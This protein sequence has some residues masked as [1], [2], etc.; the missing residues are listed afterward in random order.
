MAGELVSAQTMTAPFRGMSQLPF[1]RQI[2]LLLGLAASVAVGA[3]MILWMKDPDYQV[4]YSKLAARDQARI[5]EEL[6][7]VNIP[8]RI[9][10]GSGAVM[11]PAARL[12]DARMLVAGSGISNG[13]SA[14]YELM[15]NGSQFGTSEFMENARYQRALEGELAKSIQSIGVVQAARVHLALPK[16]SAFIRNQSPPTASV[17]VSLF[18]G[19]ALD[20]GK[21]AAIRN[22]VAAGVPNLDPARVSIV[23]QMGRLLAAGGAGETDSIGMSSSQ[24]D[25]TR[26]L[27]ESYRER[28]ESLMAPVIGIGGVRAQVAL[29]I[30][31]ST[32]EQTQESFQPDSR[33]VRSEQVQENAPAGQQNQGAAPAAEPASGVP[34]AAANQPE[35]AA[36][37]QTA[38][39]AEGAQPQ[40][41]GP[42][43]APETIKATRNYEVGKVISH[44]RAAPGRIK[45]L[46]AAVIID[47]R[48]APNAE[49]VM[50]K[51]PLT[52][53]EITRYTA[54]IK[55]AVGVDE[56]R[57]DSIQI[58]NTPFSALPEPQPLPEDPIYK[59]TWFLVVG[60]QLL[61][62]AVILLLL[63]GVLRPVLRSL[64]SRPV[65]APPIPQPQRGFSSAELRAMSQT[66]GMLPDSNLTAIRRGGDYERELLNARNMV[67]DDPRRV[68]QVVKNWVT[69]DA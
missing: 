67:G 51:V 42:A 37:A 45:R 8:H 31:F 54:L 66:G 24:Y 35:A 62:V 9:D 2:G 65:P 59:Q 1:L 64:A 39:Q 36:Q 57:G 69:T 49:G 53:E 44:T 33:V 18:S 28:I 50:E 22:I 21:A 61:A 25:Y 58:I 60:K 68:A 47:Y 3:G 56:A 4:L 17:V 19:N 55:D 10:T 16:Q 11:V 20:E 63:F 30:D 14:G 7:R 43:S 38:A 23:D 32:N 15:E 46:S 48:Q 29:D 6:S 52:E 5:V 40:P 13:D 12:D 41:G 34:G 26:K 27:E